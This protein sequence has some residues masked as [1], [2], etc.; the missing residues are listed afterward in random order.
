MP[1]QATN[2]C[3]IPFQRGNSSPRVEK[4]SSFGNEGGIFPYYLF[5]IPHIARVRVKHPIENQYTELGAF[6]RFTHACEREA[7][8]ESR[9]NNHFFGFGYGVIE[10]LSPLDIV[11]ISVTEIR[12]FKTCDF[13][14]K[15]FCVLEL[16]LSYLF[17]AFFKGIF[18]KNC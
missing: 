9:P 15:P 4:G 10:G 13:V 2:D 12:R 17:I 18:F 3:K 14:S 16:E 8:I 5:S 11:D 7:R 6:R 1:C